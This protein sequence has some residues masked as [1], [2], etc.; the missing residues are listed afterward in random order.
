MYSPSMFRRIQY[1]N[2][3]QTP[4]KV[5]KTKKGNK[6]RT[7]N[8]SQTSKTESVAVAYSN[9]RVTGKPQTRHLDNGDVVIEHTEFIRDIT[10]STDF[11]VSKIPVNPGQLT[12]FPWLSQIAPNYE[13]YKLELLEFEYQTT[14]GSTTV[15][16]VML[17]VDYDAS[18]PAP[19]DKVQFASY[20]DYTR[21]VPWKSFVQHNRKVNLDKRHSYY[22]RPGMLS[23]NQDI[24]LY[25]IGNLFIATQAMTDNSVVGELYV[26]YRVKFMTPQMVNP[27]FG[28]SKGA[29][30][31]WSTTGVTVTSGSNAPL[32]FSGDASVFTLN[33][34]SAYDGLIAGYCSSTVGNVPDFAVDVATTCTVD[35]LRVSSSLTDPVNAAAILFTMQVS[36]LA[37][38]S[39][40]MSNGQ[41][42][43]GAIVNI[44]QFN[45]QQL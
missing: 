5:A 25:D 2:K 23:A 21:E 9:K 31:T 32:I 8:A 45:S 36:M 38:Q 1:M 12:A 20:Q 10:G 28:L 44:A 13:S 15:G 7:A 11:T 43:L 27:S 26:R 41:S 40:V 39:L 34:T 14:C 18:D 3:Q 24:K 6:Q 30:A 4:K 35:N 33:A 17:G 37:G 19:V 16:I 29:S 22:V 42:P